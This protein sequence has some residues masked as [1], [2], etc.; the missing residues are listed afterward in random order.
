M[1]GDAVF[2]RVF[3]ETL[4]R[5]AERERG[6]N[7][8]SENGLREQLGT[9]RTTVRKVLAE[10]TR[11]EI[12]GPVGNRR[13]L[14][15]SPKRA[16]YFDK[17]ATLSTSSQVEKKFLEWMLRGDRKPGE[18]I[19]GLDLARQFNVSTGAVREYLNRFGRFGLIER[20][21]NSSWAV[22]GFTRDFALELFEVR[23]LFEM[24]SAI[25][26]A[27]QPAEAPAWESLRKIKREHYALRAEVN[28]RFHDFSDLD[29]RFHRLVNQANPNR[30]IDGFYEII[31]AVFHY[32]YQWN[33][34]DERQRNEVAITE[35]LRYID[36]LQARE[37]AALEK[38]CRAHL[39]TAKQTLINSI[40]V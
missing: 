7:L 19:N 18:H 1:K 27:A 35:H 23:E 32:H 11:R 10:M 6:A 33:K 12:V 28:E 9:S 39:A 2:K 36:A 29:S 37:P 24:R 30:L 22:K 14:L 3:N 40:R 25:R 4:D 8:P 16:D 15:R 26:F 38:A 34:R 17:A 21:P 13:V 20:R 31:T 5:L